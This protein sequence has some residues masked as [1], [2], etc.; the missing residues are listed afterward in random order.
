MI[1]ISHLTQ[2]LY[3]D[4]SKYTRPMA[5]AMT[6]FVTHP[7]G[8]SL[9]EFSSSGSVSKQVS[10]ALPSRFPAK[11]TPHI[12]VSP[13]TGHAFLWSP[14]VTTVWEYDTRGTRISELQ[15]GKE[16]QLV[17]AMGK[18]SIWKT[19][20]IA[21]V[22]KDGW[23]LRTRGENGKWHHYMSMEVSMFHSPDG[24]GHLIIG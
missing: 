22:I 4:R 16:V 10:L 24:L 8:I 14:H 19:E 11:S 20:S 5:G 6:A 1:S 9:I 21:C 7:H 2:P 15:V 12:T 23:V 3:L 17:V 18:G 13:T